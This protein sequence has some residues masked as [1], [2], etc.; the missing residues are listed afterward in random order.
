MNNL[1]TYNSLS[2]VKGKEVIEKQR[3]KE[4]KVEYSV[5]YRRLL[6]VLKVLIL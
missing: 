3:E 1:K 4:A 5:V 2:H 6:L